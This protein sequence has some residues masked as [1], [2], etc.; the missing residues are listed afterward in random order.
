MKTKECAKAV[1]KTFTSTLVAYEWEI[2]FKRHD[3]QLG[4]SSWRLYDIA[5]APSRLLFPSLP[6]RLSSQ[7]FLLEYATLRREHVSMIFRLKHVR[8]D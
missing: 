3:R 6:V 4:A 2:C 7:R 5:A 1:A 8:A